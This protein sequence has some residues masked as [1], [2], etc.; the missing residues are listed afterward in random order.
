MCVCI[1]GQFS[2]DLESSKY[3][4]LFKWLVISEL[5]EMSKLMSVWPEKSKLK[6][7]EKSDLKK[8]LITNDQI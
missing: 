2:I 7:D 6:N 4:E 1:L 3:Q 5:P 8:Y